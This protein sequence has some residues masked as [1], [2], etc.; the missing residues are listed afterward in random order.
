MKMKG[1]KSKSATK[2]AAVTFRTKTIRHKNLKRFTPAKDLPVI[3]MHI[4]KTLSD[5]M[6]EIARRHK[7]LRRM[8]IDGFYLEAFDDYLTSVDVPKR[9]TAIERSPVRIQ[10]NAEFIERLNS[11]A[12]VAYKREVPVSRI[13]EDAI[14][15]YLSKPE[16][17]LGSNWEDSHPERYE[18][19]NKGL[20]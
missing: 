13:I 17:F 20:K 8:F 9:I 15:D 14:K 5:G 16:H 2:Q 4:Q 6:R 18:Q 12:K 7:T 3:S 11:L 1:S 10:V 19:L